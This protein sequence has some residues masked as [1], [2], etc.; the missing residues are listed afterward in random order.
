MIC[1]GIDAGSR[2]LKI[3]VLDADRLAP[4]AGGVVDQGIE[5]DRMAGELLD[6]L[7]EGQGLCRAD[8][9]DVVATG[10]GR[11][12]V[13]IANA[14]VT[15]ITCQA[16]GVRRNVPEART[17]IDIGGQDSKVVRLN[18][19][20]TVSDFVMNDRCAAGTG[21]F[22]EMLAA[23]LGTPISEF[24]SLVG[25][26]RAPAVISSMCVVFAESEIVGLLAS[27]VLPEDTLT[28]VQTAIATRIAA[29]AAGRLSPPIAFTGGVAMVP[30]MSAAM[31]STLGQPVTLA[32]DPQL[33]GALGAALLSARRLRTGL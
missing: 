22:L 27:G 16:W 13:S 12:L 6:R 31:Q 18:G 8:L 3:V 14:T 26:S 32:P 9:G 30:G 11:K 28:G 1:A 24:G 10:Y 25:R 5:Q 23:Q 33:T 20:G 21:R 15:E 19:D 7:L 29:M 17:V 2:T 4:L